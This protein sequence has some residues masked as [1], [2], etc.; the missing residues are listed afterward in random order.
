VRLL[1]YRAGWAFDRDMEPGVV[2]AYANMAKYLGAELAIMAVDR[3][4]ETLGGNGFSEENTLIY[5]WE[6][7]RLL[8]TAPVSKEM[9]LNYIS[10][11]VLGLPRSY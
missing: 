11:H 8:K 9:I 6:A 3:A 2:G 1:T 4:I 10:E 5:I 7:A